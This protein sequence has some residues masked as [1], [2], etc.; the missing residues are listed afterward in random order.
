MNDDLGCIVFLAEEKKQENKK[1]KVAMW[2]D[3]NN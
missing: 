2:F 3:L 1:E